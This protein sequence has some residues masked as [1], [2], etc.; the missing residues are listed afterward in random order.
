MVSCRKGSAL[1]HI[2]RQSRSRSPA[3]RNFDPLSVFIN[4][5]FGAPDREPAREG[6][7]CL[8]KPIA[9]GVVAGGNT[10]LAVFA[11]Q[12]LLDDQLTIRIK[13]LADMYVQL[14]FNHLKISQD[15]H[16]SDF[17]SLMAIKILCPLQA[18]DE[19]IFRDSCP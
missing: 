15:T 6:W 19:A 3:Q 9:G 7:I 5:G 18:I 17:N 8:Q 14:R 2:G 12:I 13:R 4:E 1:P 11:N 16:C 10:P